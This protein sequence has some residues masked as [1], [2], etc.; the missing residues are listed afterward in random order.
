[1][2]YSIREESVSDEKAIDDLLKSSFPSQAEALLVEKLRRNG[3]LLL[4]L[5]AEKDG[6]ILGHIAFSR[7]AVGE[8]GKTGV[9]LAPLAVK[10][11]FRGKGIGAALVKAGHDL[12]AGRG[13][14][15]SVVLGEADYYA[16]FGYK[17]AIEF[18]IRCPY[19]VPDIHYRA[20]PLAPGG[21][22]GVSGLAS[23]R[24]EFAEL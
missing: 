13:E 12:L 5:V 19:Q 6:E 10:A 24:A 1:M 3:A 7:L 9:A 20:L 16:R 17:P 15:Y 18:G 2:N 23:Y 8:S 4:S 14:L 21:L 22:D 11:P